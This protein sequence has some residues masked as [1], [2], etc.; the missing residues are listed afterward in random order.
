MNVCLIF[1]KCRAHT[2]QEMLKYLEK[3]DIK[4]FVIPSGC[5]SLVQPLDVSINKPFKD[6]MKKYFNDWFT[7][8]CEK[9]EGNEFNYKIEK[10]FKVI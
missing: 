1:D 7:N 9:S 10:S 3:K 8:E 2:T 5:T 4:T 6:R